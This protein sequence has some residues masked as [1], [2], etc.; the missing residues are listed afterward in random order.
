MVNKQINK[1]YDQRFL[2]NKKEHTKFSKKEY[3]RGMFFNSLIKKHKKV[4]VLGPDRGQVLKYYYKDKDITCADISKKVLAEVKRFSNKLCC[5]DFE[6]K[7]PFKDN[8]YDVV[9]A[10]DVIEHMF[11]PEILIK[12]SRRVL[13][14]NGLF[15]GST[16]NAF[17]WRVRIAT[18]LNIQKIK[19]D[20]EHI[21]FFNNNIL[22]E[23]L[24][25]YFKKVK[26]LSL[27]KSIPFKSLFAYN[28]VWICRK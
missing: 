20:N 23:L 14:E 3:L 11:N 19:W 4:L 24:V 18:L 22:N 2:I 25:K 27:K 9:V 1:F 12:E 26:I 10:G 7:F 21:R 8:F 6:D 13:K 28:F 5:F 16:P 15:I 17:N